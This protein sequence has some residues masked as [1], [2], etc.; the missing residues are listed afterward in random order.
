[1][2]RKKA[3][4]VQPSTVGKVKT[5]I[6]LIYEETNKE[7]GYSGTLSK[8]G[9]RFANVVK[10]LKRRNVIYNIGTVKSPVY[11]WSEQAMAPTKCFYKSVAQRV[12]DRERETGARWRERHAAAKAVPADQPLDIFAGIEV[13]VGASDSTVVG[14]KD[15]PI[16]E[17]VSRPASTDFF[18]PISSVISDE[19]KKAL[20]ELRKELDKPTTEDQRRVTLEV[21]S[22]QELWDELKRRGARIVNGG[23]KIV[24]EVELF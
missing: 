7:G 24:K 9:G 10:E 19:D 13:P 20:E 6:D 2:A 18:P 4:T 8:F 15:N 16:L 23:L 14:V 3:T 1:M 5:A 21:F 22:D 12:I 17:P 11:K